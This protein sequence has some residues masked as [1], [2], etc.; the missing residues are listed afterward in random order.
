MAVAKSLK[1]YLKDKDVDYRVTRHASRASASRAAQAAHVSGE[2]VA[3]AVVVF[4][5]TNYMLAVVPA[6][7]RLDVRRLEELLDRRLSLATEAE[8]E[9]LFQDCEIGAVPPVG[10][11]YGLD[12]VMDDCLA[13]QPDIYFEAGDHKSFVHLS[14]ASFAKLMQGA[15]QEQFS[16]HI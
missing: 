5:G 10:A 14:G 2:Q 1:K 15:R 9:V 3:K 7:H 6:T 12:V 4:D 11:L 16:D 13:R 8:L